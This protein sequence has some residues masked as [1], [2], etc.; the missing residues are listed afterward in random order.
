MV[1]GERDF[2][3]G[4]GVPPRE[5]HVWYLRPEHLKSAHS[6]L[7]S[8]SRLLNAEERARRD[9][10]TFEAGRLEYLVAHALVR[11]TL[12][13][14]AS[15]RPEDW[16]FA[17]NPYGRPEISAP[18]LTRPLRFN[19]S[20]CNGL[21]ACAVVADRDIGIDVE[22]TNRSTRFLEVARGSFSPSEFNELSSLPPRS[23][24]AR[25]FEYWTL[26][27]SYIKA[28]GMGLAI[29]LEEFSFIL[30]PQRPIRITFGDRIL[31]EPESWQFELLKVTERHQ[32]A[33]AIRKGAAAALRIIMKEHVPGP[34]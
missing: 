2:K 3:S 31:D 25:F 18:P 7:E 34:A 30:G 20:H 9:R 4:T 33:L 19:L 13:R 10:F 12:S 17:M 1:S 22:D 14:Y 16:V 6:V 23:Q 26:K 24:R 11:L 32:M 8:Y 5:A 15:V 29:P 27:E 21:I 28:R